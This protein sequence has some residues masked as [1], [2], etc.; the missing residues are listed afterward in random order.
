MPPP[1]IAEVLRASGN[2]RSSHGG[3]AGAPRGRFRFHC[4]Y[5]TGP[6]AAV[7]PRCQTNLVAGTDAS[8]N[9]DTETGAD[10]YPSDPPVADRQQP[11]G[12]SEPRRRSRWNFIARHWR[13]EFPLG[14]SFWGFAFLFTVAF[15]FVSYLIIDA[16]P[17]PTHPVTVFFWIVGAWSLGMILVTWQLVGVFRS[18]RRR[19]R[20]RWSAG[21]GAFWAI[22]AMIW[23]GLTATVNLSDL[24]LEGT[25][26]FR[27]SYEIAF[28]G[29]PD[30]PDYEI[31]ID[32]ERGIITVSGGIKFGIA[33]AIEQAIA[34]TPDASVLVLDSPGGRMGAAELATD[35]VLRAGL[36]THVEGSCASACTLVFAAGTERTIGPLASLGYHSATAGYRYEVEDPLANSHM[37]AV[38]LDIGFDPSF[39]ERVLEVP[40]WEIW[41]PTSNELMRAG[42][43]TGVRSLDE[44]A[45]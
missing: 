14:W 18:A 27:I 45:R 12:H 22:T 26:Q 21:R 10:L 44:V 5:E 2:G 25:W 16:L 36:R 31:T 41:E 30:I 37:R 23:V 8:R 4:G 13:G 43:I 42:V 17:P 6:E 20:E 40:W 33:E 35:V 28:L 7:C 15:Y 29:D 19:R 3:G 38:M 9:F 11:A 32:E 1:Q 34:V 24:A 39:V